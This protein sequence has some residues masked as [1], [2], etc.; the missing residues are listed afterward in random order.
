MRAGHRTSTSRRGRWPVTGECDR[1]PAR[2]KARRTVRRDGSGIAEPTCKRGYRNRSDRTPRIRCDQGR[3]VTTSGTSRHPGCT[4]GNV[5]T[6]GRVVHTPKQAAWLTLGKTS[7]RYGDQVPTPHYGQPRYRLIA[8]ELRRRIESGDIPPSNLLPAESALST[9]FRASRGTIRQALAVLREA[10]LVATEQGRGTYANTQRLKNE[11]SGSTESET[12]QRK[13]A[14][15][16]ELAALF[17]VEVGT[18][19]I[20]HESVGLTN[21][22]VVVTRTYRLVRPPEDADMVHG[23]RG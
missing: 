7:A 15:D 21:G 11:P 22:E 4:Q 2:M 6:S 19:L 8:D 9:E 3:R 13:V 23:G 12:R 14:A 1:P 20:E 17:S 5:P 10:R 16:R 18:V